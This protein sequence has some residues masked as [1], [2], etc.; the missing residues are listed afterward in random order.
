MVMG[1]CRYVDL[2]G[3]LLWLHEAFAGANC[4]YV[5]LVPSRCRFMIVW[6]QVRI[7]G[8]GPLSDVTLIC[9]DLYYGFTRLLQVRTHDLPSL[10]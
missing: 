10:R 4:C 8:H 5:D 1:R 3:S 7:H 9:R 6:L 2:P